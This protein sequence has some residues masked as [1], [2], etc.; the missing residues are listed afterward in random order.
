MDPSSERGGYFSTGTPNNDRTT[1]TTPTTTMDTVAMPSSELPPLLNSTTTGENTASTLNTTTQ[2]KAASH[3]FDSLH[4]MDIAPRAYL[5]Q[6]VVPT[7]LEGM[8][9]LV[10]E[11]PAD[12]L[13]FLGQ[14]LLER[15]SS[16][17]SKQ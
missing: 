14:F 5:D 3:S 15:S 12:P 17:N 1:T 6:T 11:R 16:N 2:A 7:L 13:A 4:K 8:K 9:Q 10:S